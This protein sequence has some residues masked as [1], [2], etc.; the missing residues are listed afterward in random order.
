MITDKFSHKQLH[1]LD[2]A[3]Q[4]IA[5]KGFEATSVRE[6]CTKAGVNIA[7][8]SYYFGSKDKMLGY[9]Y[10]Y[11]VYKTK[12]T[13]AEFAHTI[14]NGNP[15]MQMK[16]L[17]RFTVEQMFKYK[18]FHGF[19]KQEFRHTERIHTELQD[20]YSVAVEKLNDVIKKG[21][22]TGVFEYAPRP[23]EI[24]SIIIGTVLFAVRNPQFYQRYI[25]NA[26]DDNYL[27]LAEIKV[28]QSIYQAVFLLLGYH[29][30]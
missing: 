2:V 18:Y 24:L 15:E 3:E 23:E 21:V 13:F 10:Q 27:A 8:I 1:I 14:K 20:F 19:A 17:I 12:E 4:I 22:M 7:M 30:K 16:E 11:R 5:E 25:P 28:R 29:P 26:N 6:I 9:L